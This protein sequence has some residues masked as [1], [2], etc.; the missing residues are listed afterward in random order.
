M[1]NVQAK[2]E[3]GVGNPFTTEPHNGQSAAAVFVVQGGHGPPA[4]EPGFGETPPGEVFEFSKGDTKQ[5]AEEVFEI[6]EED[7]VAQKIPEKP[8]QKILK[9][10]VH[11]SNL[12]ESTRRNL[13]RRAKRETLKAV[14]DQRNAADEPVPVIDY[15]RLVSSMGGGAIRVSRR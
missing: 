14:R 7:T 15:E 1:F 2:R 5:E 11:R 4:D 9:K 3:P 12:N 6:I 10:P 13:R 8:A